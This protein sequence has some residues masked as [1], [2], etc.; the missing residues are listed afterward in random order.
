MVPK[1]LVIKLMCVCELNLRLFLH[2]FMYG[3][4]TIVLINEKQYTWAEIRDSN[5]NIGYC[6]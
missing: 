1:T 5:L 2:Y 3:P 4:F 6:I